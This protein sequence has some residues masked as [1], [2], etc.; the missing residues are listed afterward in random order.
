MSDLAAIAKSIADA[1]VRGAEKGGKAIVEHYGSIGKKLLESKNL[2]KS[3]ESDAAHSF[4]NIGKN[5]VKDLEHGADQAGKNVVGDTEKAGGNAAKNAETKAAEDA[6]PDGESGDCGDPIDMVTGEMFLPQQDIALP[7]VLP[8][9]LNRRHGSAFRH[10]RFFGTTWASTLDQRAAVDGNEIRVLLEDGRFLRYPRP[11]DAEPVLPTHGPRWPL[12]WD[13]EDDVIIVSQE[14]LGRA[15]R[16]PAGT[17]PAA[18]RFL[19]EITDRAGNEITIARGEDGVPTDLRHSGGYHV[20]IGSEM[21]PAGPRITNVSLV[22]PDGGPDIGVR[23]FQYDPSSRL[24]GVT[25]G[26]GVPLTFEYDDQERITRWEDR[27][28]YEYRYTY[29]ADGRVGRGE[30]SGGLLDVFLEYD[31]EDRTTTV[32]DG[33][34]QATVY[35]WN[36][37]F[38]VEK[39][40]DPLGNHTSTEWDENGNI[41]AT[42]DA[43]GRQTRFDRN[44]RGNPVRVVHP[45]GSVVSVAYD[46]AGQPVSATSPDGREWRY[47]YGPHG[48]MTAVTDPSGAV[49]RY[50]YDERGRLT[51]ISDAHGDVTRFRC[52]AAGLPV[53]VVDPLGNRTTC[54]YDAFGRVTEEVDPLGAVTRY[55][56]S[57]EGD[58]LSV[59]HPD[60]SSE[61]WE[62]DPEGNLSSYTDAA[63]RVTLFEH[64]PLDLPSRRTDPDRSVY[65]FAYTPQLQLK[66]VTNGDGLSWRYEYDAAGNLVAETDFNGVRQEYSFDAASQ[67]IARV[68]QAG[69][70]VSYAYDALGRIIERVSGHDVY[71]YAYDFDGNVTHADG[72]GVV[73]DYA[74]DAAGRITAET[75][76]GRTLTNRYD[77]A[78]L[79]LSRTTPAGVTSE[80]AYDAAG[81]PARLTIGG[82]AVEFGYDAAG[83]ETSRRLGPGAALTQTYDAAARPLTQSIWTLGQADAAESTAIGPTVGTPPWRTVQARTYSYEPSG[84]PVGITD[85]LR[86]TRE[87]ALSPAGRVTRVQAATWREEYSY[88][89]LGNVTAAQS[90]VADADQ[91]ASGDRALNGTL[92]RRA[93]RNR[94]KYDQAGRLIQ[95]TRRTISGQARTWTYTW[96]ADDELISVTTPSNGSWRYLYDPFGR[97]V[98][99]RRIPDDAPS[100]AGQE[101]EE[102]WFTW[103]G[104]RIAEQSQKTAD[105]RLSTITWEYEP[106]DVT[107]VTQA[108]GTLPGG[109]D[110]DAGSGASADGGADQAEIDRRFFSIVTDLAGTPQELVTP[111]GKIAWH[112]TSSIW[113]G[114]IIAPDSAVEC[115]L[116]F[117]G[118][119]HDAET[120]LDYNVNRYY[121]SSTGRYISPDP[122][123]LDAS[124]NPH[125]YVDN[126][127]SQTDPL[128]LA[129]CRKV[130]YGGN[131]I[132][133]EAVNARRANKWYNGR[134]VS[135]YKYE[136]ENGATNFIIAQSKGKHAERRAMDAFNKMKQDVADRGGD[137]SKIK[138]KQI[139]TELEPCGGIFHNCK[140]W[141]DTNAPGVPVSYS[142]QYGPDKLGHKLGIGALRGAVSQIKR[143][144]L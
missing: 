82:K 65:Q 137:A 14:D 113:G 50:E 105:G 134:N 22:A 94:Y 28:G 37:R 30:G 85:E 83:N 8:L 48:L 121:D 3:V 75:V 131:N 101:P 70:R 62:Y 114:T 51:A 109:T 9:T 6:H 111:D 130:K 81:Q 93:G 18:D 44:E 19:A 135:V 66:T 72:P 54:R 87:F 107:P 110:G 12:T 86:G 26:S 143:G 35:H 84:L 49:N 73:I 68:N 53:E 95:K 140:K 103:D 45:D 31:L 16:F 61:S 41:A 1:M 125:A 90:P 142:F 74:R 60:G 139:Y 4:E 96:G 63:G 27:N 104:P 76:N 40:T 98:A 97:R 36:D 56:W 43:V 57:I 55:A 46:D 144:Q 89:H 34:G 106:G 79:R 100:G 33:T 69:Q 91:E 88:D 38:K 39:V 127:F 112:L 102:V 42:T 124:P 52:D 21:L 58:P 10:G 59:L 78:G 133:K 99:K 24:T 116:R 7:G 136:D 141:L 118:Q 122:V 128:G 108:C 32:T 15:L 17:D 117:A 120:G 129:P 2:Y 11:E 67:L 92:L 13:H 47:E 64:G 5:G 71:R 20:K 126:P 123:G 77:V 119:Y 115:P 25:D 132:S 23:R 80:W 29:R 138:L